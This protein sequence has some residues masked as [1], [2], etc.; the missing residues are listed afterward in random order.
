[1][2]CISVSRSRGTI[3]LMPWPT[4]AA[5]V[6]PNSRSAA[7]FQPVMVPSSDFVTMASFD[8]STAALNRR[9]RAA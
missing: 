8:D 2:S 1:M 5:A 9:S 6:N 4:A 7:G 3:I